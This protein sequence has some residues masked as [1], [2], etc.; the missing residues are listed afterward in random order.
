[1]SISRAAIIPENTMTTASIASQVIPEIHPPRKYR[2]IAQ[3]IVENNQ[4]VC[5][6]LLD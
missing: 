6:W 1:M 5:K 3:W 4:L 2:L